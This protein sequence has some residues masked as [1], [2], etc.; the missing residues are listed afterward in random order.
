MPGTPSSS[1]ALATCRTEHASPYL[2][3]VVLAE[4]RGA[5]P[6]PSPSNNNTW[7]QLKPRKA[8]R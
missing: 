1:E 8:G 6:A 7:L 2:L 4:A 3:S 5:L